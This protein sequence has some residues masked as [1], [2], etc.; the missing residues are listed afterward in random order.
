[1]KK[2]KYGRIDSRY[3]TRQVNNE[4]HTHTHMANNDLIISEIMIVFRQLYFTKER[5]CAGH[6]K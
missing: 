3:K 6:D 5:H 4:V 1:M 2:S